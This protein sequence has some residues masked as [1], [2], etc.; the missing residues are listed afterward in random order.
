MKITKKQKYIIEQMGRGNAQIASDVAN[1]MHI[2]RG[3]LD[4]LNAVQNVHPATAAALERRG[5]IRVT[6][7]HEGGRTYRRAILTAAGMEMFDR[8]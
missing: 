1:A 5:L 6:S 2:D 3:S 7:T 8:L 4:Y